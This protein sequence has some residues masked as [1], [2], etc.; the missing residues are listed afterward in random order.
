MEVGKAAAALGAG[1]LAPEIERACERWEIDTPLLQ[2]HFLAQ[3]AHESAGFHRLVENFNY[4]V[5]GLL[6]TFRRNRISAEECMKWGRRP[7]RKA[8]QEAIANR[9][10]GGLWGRNRLGNTEPGDG[11]KFRGRGLAQLTGRDNY[12]RCGAALGIDLINHPDLLLQ[13]RY[14]AQSAGWVWHSHRCRPYAAR[15]DVIAVSVAWN[16][17]KN[18]IDDRIHWLKRAKQTLGVA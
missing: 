12:T 13:P 11:W 4:S 17:G 6:K 14:A 7:G 10:Y 9:V 1:A 15:D 5:E 16:G 3:I 2:A 8:D 18:G